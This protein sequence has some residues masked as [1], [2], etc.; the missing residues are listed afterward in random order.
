METDLLESTLGQ[1]VS[2]D[3]GQGLVR[4]I[5]GLFDQCQFLA[6]RLVQ[7]ILHTETE[8]NRISEK[9]RGNKQPSEDIIRR[10]LFLRGRKVIC[11][12][13]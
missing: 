3:P 5:V 8:K 4:I 2:F 12:S 11:L 13:K 7:P 6:L 9:I 1:Q 10:D